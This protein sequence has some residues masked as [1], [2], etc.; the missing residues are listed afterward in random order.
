[1]DDFERW[2]QESP[3]CRW[4]RKKMV[5]WTMGLTWKKS[6]RECCSE[7]L[8]LNFILSKMTLFKDEEIIIC[9]RSL[10]CVKV[11]ERNYNEIRQVRW[12]HVYHFWEM[13][14]QMSN[15]LIIKN[16]KFYPVETHGTFTPTPMNRETWNSPGQWI[17]PSFLPLSCLQERRLPLQYHDPWQTVCWPFT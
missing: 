13:G 8:W 2:T 11:I 5:K 1:M 7:F 3:G 9:S 4:V 6:S 16:I 15:L 17:F 14:Y 10:G 12:E